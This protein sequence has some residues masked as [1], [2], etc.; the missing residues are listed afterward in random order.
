M[1]E[2]E[3]SGTGWVWQEGQVNRQHEHMEL[4]FVTNPHAFPREYLP[5]ALVAPGSEKSFTVQFLLTPTPEHPET[6]EALALALQSLDF[7]LTEHL[8]PAGFPRGQRARRKEGYNPWHYAI[9][10]ATSTAAN[11]YAQIHWAYF[12]KGTEEGAH[13]GV[14]LIPLSEQGKA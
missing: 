1:S 8:G 13:Q 14:L 7:Y 11:L 3:S 10:H 4:A 2:L 5:V 12:P 9:Y 6:A